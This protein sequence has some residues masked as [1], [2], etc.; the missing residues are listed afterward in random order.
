MKF[1]IGDIIVPSR[2]CSY[3][4]KLRYKIVDID[5]AT[6]YQVLDILDNY[7]IKYINQ[8]LDDLFDLD[9]KFERK[10]KLQKIYE[11]I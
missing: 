5:Y 9:I 2:S 8:S 3:N 4:L 1:K 11:Q 7:K 6:Y 10:E